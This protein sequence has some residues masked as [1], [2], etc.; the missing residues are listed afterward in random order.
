MFPPKYLCDLGGIL[1]PQ[2]AK[3]Q[4]EDLL[5]QLSS[6]PQL[7]DSLDL[8]RSQEFAF[9]TSTQVKLMLLIQEP[10]FDNHCFKSPTLFSLL[11]TRFTISTKRKEPL[12]CDTVRRLK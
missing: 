6:S 8:Q 12:S 10:H 3:C 4:L 5:K 11:L 2:Q 1:N 7:S 9:L